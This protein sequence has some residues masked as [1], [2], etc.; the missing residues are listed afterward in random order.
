MSG[1]IYIDPP[2]ERLLDD[3]FFSPEGG[4]NHSSLARCLAY[5]KET[6]EA[7]GVPVHTADRLPPPRGA[8]R[9]LFVSIGN[10]KNHERIAQRP[11]VVMSAFLVTEA[12]VVEPSIYEG[13]PAAAARFRRIYSCIDQEEVAEFAGARVDCI[14]L[15]WP[16]DFRGVDTELW[17]RSDRRFLV[18]INMNKLPR[19]TQYELFTERMRAVEFFSRTDDIDLYGIGW[20]KA[21]MRMGHTGLPRAHPARPDR[22]SQSRRSRG[23]R[24]AAGSRTQALPG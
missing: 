20:K 6:L 10:H 3:R 9:H 24:P 12:P 17:S 23:A 21:S 8:E 4:S 1:G 5:V 11:D 2:A 18:M 22:A 13:L 14:P 7:R 15:R 16:I 19:L